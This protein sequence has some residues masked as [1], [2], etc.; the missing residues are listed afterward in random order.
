MCSTG[1]PVGLGDA[2]HELVGD[3]LRVPSG[4]VEMTISEMWKYCSAFIAAV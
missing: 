2:L 3:P 4:S 1:L